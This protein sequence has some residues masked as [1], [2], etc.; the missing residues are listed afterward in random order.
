MLAVVWETEEGPWGAWGDQYSRDSKKQI[1][2]AEVNKA[3]DSVLAWFTFVR[4]G[5][6]SSQSCCGLLSRCQ[7]A[8]D[9]KNRFPTHTC[10]WCRDINMERLSHSGCSSVKNHRMP[11]TQLPLVAI[12]SLGVLQDL[13]LCPISFLMSFSTTLPPLISF[14][15]LLLDFVIFS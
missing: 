6:L 5:Y 12:L 3:D 4:A 11:G 13:T 15:E 10:I 1:G 9:K 2:E 8:S 14:F 7:P